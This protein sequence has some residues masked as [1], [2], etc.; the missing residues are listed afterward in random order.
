MALKGDRN[1]V[2]TDISFFMNEAAERGGIVCLSTAGSGAAMDQAAALVTYSASPSGRMPVGMLLNDMVDIDQ[3][4]YHINFHKDQMI[5]GSKVTVAHEGVFITNRIYT[6]YTPVAGA[7]ATVGMSGYLSG[8]TSAGAA[9]AGMV[10]D[11]SVENA[12]V[13]RWL[14]TKDEDGYAKV[15][16]KLPSLL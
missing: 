6:G 3:T 9:G 5:K 8:I 15:Y 12:R 10:T 2:T 11:E 1:V 7:V 14:S 4:K 13:G 16:V